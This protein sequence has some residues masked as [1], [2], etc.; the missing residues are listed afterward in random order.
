MHVP[1]PTTFVQVPRVYSGVMNTQKSPLSL[2]GYI[3]LAILIVV[4]GIALLYAY[5]AFVPPA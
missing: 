1:T 4:L 3:A 5:R 2:T